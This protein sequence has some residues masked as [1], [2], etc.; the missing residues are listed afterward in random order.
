MRSVNEFLAR[1]ENYA[2]FSSNSPW[3]LPGAPRRVVGFD[4]VRGR[5]CRCKMTAS[6]F[7]H[8]VSMEL[9]KDPITRSWVVVG[10]PERAKDRAEPCPLC[11][12]ASLK[13]AGAARNCPRRATGKCAPTRIFVRSIASRATRRATPT[14]FSTAWPRSAPTRSSSRRRSTRESLTQLTDEEIERVLRSLR[15]ADRRT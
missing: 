8:R 6:N 3:R 10:H 13:G 15:D 5:S 12:E 9:R 7:P 11:R 1:K 14:E 4:P 2:H